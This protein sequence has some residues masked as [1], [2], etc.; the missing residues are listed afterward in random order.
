MVPQSNGLVELSEETDEDV[1]DE[2]GEHVVEMFDCSPE[3]KEEE[4][5]YAETLW[6]QVDSSE[7]GKR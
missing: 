3:E 2:D 7:P 4:K 6:G 1:P 5:I